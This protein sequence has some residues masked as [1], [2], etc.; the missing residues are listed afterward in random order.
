[1]KFNGIVAAA[2]LIG[3]A[4][5]ISAASIHYRRQSD[6]PS[7]RNAPVA[8][9]PVQQAAVAEQGTLP[10]S[11][12][13]AS[14]AP[15]EPR[16]HVKEGKL[17][18]EPARPFNHYRVGDNSVIALYA[19]GPVIWLGGS[20]G[21]VRYD[22]ATR[23]F[24]TYLARDGLVANMVLCVA[25]IG[26]RIAVGT[27][28]GGISL[29]DSGGQAWENYGKPEGRIDDVVYGAI[30]TSTSEVWIATG[31]GA[32]RVPSGA[33]KDRAKW[34][35]HT[36]A[37]TGG[38][39]PNNKVYRIAEAGDGSIWF[40][41]RAGV[42][43]FRGGKW[44][45]WTRADG[46]GIPAAA[47]GPDATRPQAHLGP[48]QNTAHAGTRAAFA[49]DHVSALEIGR[50]GDVWV[51][52]RGAGLARFDGKAW[53]SYSVTDGLPSNQ[54][55]ALHFD[56]KGRLWIGTESGLAVLENG[57]FRILTT[58]Q[59]LLGDSVLSIATDSTGSLWAGTFGGVAQLVGH[60][61]N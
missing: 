36:A 44:A 12:P 46:V 59:G 47:S 48:A 38:G 60:A 50:N 26:G 45:N 3:A 2:L 32:Y 37:S 34:E 24:K 5:L 35:L 13:A 53:R 4:A 21:L 51:G 41:T 49:P 40:T 61:A 29:L 16:R 42:A 10:A 1:M 19:E 18:V 9:A 30:Q 11:R 52:T 57:K 25:K 27:H 31:A 28:G 20:G 55:F 54:V 43:R 17:E 58:A 22:S 33:M 8:P 39:L 14:A 6:S 56:R 15:A 7:N 23:E